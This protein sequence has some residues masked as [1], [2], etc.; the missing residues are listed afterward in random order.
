MPIRTPLFL[1]IL[2]VWGDIADAACGSR[3]A[4][5][6]SGLP[7]SEVAQLDVAYLVGERSTPTSQTKYYY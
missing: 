5:V 6:W 1:L 2:A 3:A 4:W 7:A